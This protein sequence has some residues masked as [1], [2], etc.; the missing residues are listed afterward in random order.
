MFSKQQQ[1]HKGKT[2]RFGLCLFS[3]FNFYCRNLRIDLQ[4]W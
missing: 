4:G 3:V 2:K 1:K